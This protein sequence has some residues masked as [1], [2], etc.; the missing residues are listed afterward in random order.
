MPSSVSSHSLSSCPSSPSPS[1]CP[2]APAPGPSSSSGGP[3]HRKK[4]PD[5]TRD[6]RIEVL[7]LHKIAGWNMRK[8]A[9]A[10]GI[11]YDQV[12]QTVEAGRPTPQRRKGRNP[13][14]TT[15]QI[16]EIEQYIRES[17]DGRRMSYKKLAEG[18][19]CLFSFNNTYCSLL[20]LL[21]ST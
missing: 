10:L 18:K 17:R 6:T 14:F 21:L 13:V 12:R 4:Q 8:V 9:T 11:T 1:P 16:D 3:I 2:P 5:L 20:I 15:E 7:A 19:N